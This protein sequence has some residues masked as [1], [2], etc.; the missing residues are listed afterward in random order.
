MTHLLVQRP[1]GGEQK[2][3]TWR[4]AASR[5]DEDIA[6]I[7]DEPTPPG[8][9]APPRLARCPVHWFPVCGPAEKAKRLRESANAA[10]RFH[11]SWLPSSPS[12]NCPGKRTTAPA[13][14][15]NCE[16][17]QMA[18]VPLRCRHSLFL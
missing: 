15:H 1:D 14:P 2:P 6:R 8:I 13:N 18:R 17:M 4:V 5:L 7:V 12:A 10:S 3:S 9:A 16:P 11:Q